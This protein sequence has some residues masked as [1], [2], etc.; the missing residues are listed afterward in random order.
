MDFQKL[1]KSLVA[2]GIVGL[3]GSL[4]WWFRFYSDVANFLGG[5]QADVWNRDTLHCLISNSGPCGLV[6]GVAN[7]AGAYAYQP[8]AFWISAAV[9]LGGLIIKF[10]ATKAS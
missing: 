5:P 7:A 1:S 8:M 4:F 10:S 3:A 6:T 2:L 9:L